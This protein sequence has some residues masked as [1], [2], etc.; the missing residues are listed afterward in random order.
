MMLLWP[1][2]LIEAAGSLLLSG[3]VVAALVVVGRA[4]GVGRAR[5]LVIEGAVAGLDLKLAASLLKTIELHTWQQ[6]GAFAAILALRILIK[7]LF[8]WERRHLEARSREPMRGAAV[9]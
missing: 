1:I 5:W 8:V 9:P 4:R 6:L 2:L 3:Y 7:Q